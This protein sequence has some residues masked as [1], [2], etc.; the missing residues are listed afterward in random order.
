MGSGNQL[1]T[2]SKYHDRTPNQFSM[3][4]RTFSFGSNMSFNRAGADNLRVMIRQI[5]D[6]TFSGMVA[7]QRQ[8]IDDVKAKIRSKRKLHEYS[9]TKTFHLLGD[10][11]DSRVCKMRQMMD[12]FN[13]IFAQTFL[14]VLTP[15]MTSLLD[16]SFETSSHLPMEIDLFDHAL[17]LDSRSDKQ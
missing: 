1:T 8:L 2:M 12:S 7:A 4:I 14:E 9:I 3:P 17:Q 5:T 6:E 13:T 11:H 16:E 10:L 15:E